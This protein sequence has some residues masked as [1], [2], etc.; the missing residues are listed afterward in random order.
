MTFSMMFDYWTS[1]LDALKANR[2]RSLLTLLGVV[3]GVALVI[4]LISLGEACKAYVSNQV[5][6]L[7]FGSNALVVHPGKMDPPI[8]PSKLTYED[9]RELSHRVP[10][11]IDQVPVLIGSAY[12]KMGRDEYKTSIWGLTENYPN[13]LN[14]HVERGR[15]FAVADVE[16]HRK[17]CVIGQKVA[18][19][20]FTGR[21]PIGETLRISGSRF[22]ILGVM[23][24][25]G[26]ML[27]LD[28]D[29]MVA[30]PITSASD[31]LDT[32]RLTEIIVWTDSVA[33][34]AAVRDRI[35]SYLNSRHFAGDDFH[36]HTQAEMLS[37][38]GTLTTTLTLVVTALASVS[39]A[40]GA[41]GITNIMLVSV[42]ERTREIGIRKALGARSRDIF[43]QFFM[44]ALVVSLGGGL[45]G[46]LLGCGITALA[47][48]AMGLPSAISVWSIQLGFLN[49]GLVG[50]V[51]G[52]FPAL[53][54]A[55]ADPIKALRYE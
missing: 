5:G 33:T 11:V 1:A 4:V 12:A 47:T 32:R 28:M 26:E 34:M 7:G 2:L 23:E 15:F 3:I 19:K 21:E 53:R 16:Q 27:G 46:I 49:S 55:K 54:A 37:V 14:Y 38:L 18:H 8:E 20:L 10:G 9:A 22:R 30:M 51:A 24:S 29:D 52:V 40:V 48:R 17:V 45:L 42:M 44:E 35:S 13:L 25:K 36:F 31:L 6:G 39:L 41:I 43:W 50:L